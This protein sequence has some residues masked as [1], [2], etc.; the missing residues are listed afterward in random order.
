MRMR[1]STTRWRLHHRSMV[2]C[3][4]SAACLVYAISLSLQRVVPA[5]KTALT[6]SLA[7]NVEPAFYLR[8]VMSLAAGALAA[9]LAPSTLSER[10]LAWGT[11]LVMGMATLLVC[12]FP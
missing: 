12:L 9:L 1:R 3:G 10:V 2:A 8:V 11:S 5:I 4:V 7:E 6:L